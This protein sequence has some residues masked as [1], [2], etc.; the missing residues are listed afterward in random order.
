[1]SPAR[2][3]KWFG[4]AAGTVC[5]A[6][7]G[8]ATDLTFHIAISTPS[9]TFTR[10]FSAALFAI[11][12]GILAYFALTRREETLRDR[13]SIHF[14][15]DNLEL[16]SESALTREMDK[17]QL[18]ERARAKVLEVYRALDHSIDAEKIY[19]GQRKTLETMLDSELK[20]EPVPPG[21]RQDLRLTSVP[22]WVV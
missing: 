6:V 11:G 7:A 9:D 22:S 4:V 1:M 13:K 15:D 2:M 14:L 17:L 21:S 12:G 10:S 3:K 18:S 20:R 19:A 16:V 8:V 5:G